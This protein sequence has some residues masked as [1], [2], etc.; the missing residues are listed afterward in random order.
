MSSRCDGRAADQLREV[1]FDRDFQIHPTGSV[2]AVFGATRVICAVTAVD[3]VPRW[4]REQGVEGGW[5]TGE[6][7]MLPGATADRTERDRRRGAPSGRSSEIQRL[8]G[9]SLRMAVNRSKLGARTFYVDCDVLDADGG[10]RCAAI[11]GASVAL[12]IALRKLYAAGRLPEL[13]LV[14]NVAA[15]SVGMRKGEPLLDLCYEEDSSADVD[16]NVVMADDG[17]LI[18]IQGTAES[19]PFSESDLTAMLALARKGIGEI[20]ELQQGALK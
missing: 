15:V 4:M 19:E 11:C 12:Q 2:L 13:P 1:R 9:R 14:R 16:M 7:A 17:R 8:V 3:G 18:E 20:F 10:T 5:V 6:Y